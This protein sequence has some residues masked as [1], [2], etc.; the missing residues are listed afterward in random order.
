MSTHKFNIEIA[1][2]YGLKEAIILDYLSFW[3]A[4][5]EANNKNFF[6]GRH[7]VYNSIKAFCELFP[8]LS[9]SQII[10]CLNN[11]EDKN[12]IISSNYNETG[13]D[14]TKW[15]SVKQE[16]HLAKMTNAFTQNDT[17]HLPPVTN[18]FVADSKPIPSIRPIINK[19]NNKKS[20]QLDL[21]EFIDAQLW[22]DFIE[23]RIKIK[24]HMTDRAK[25]MAIKQLSNF[26]LTKAGSA[27]ASL[28]QSILCSYKG[29]FMPTQKSPSTELSN[30]N[31][32][33]EFK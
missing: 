33:V 23:M 4:K 17:M 22:H 7:W 1:Q 10:R 32:K 24:S 16:M 29:L 18:P 19:K 21:P 5:N 8:Y 13:Y 15:Y 27:N 3:Q 12:I 20:L 2:K 30:F 14:R 28:E 9:K 26:E 6:D 11:L 25:K 31:E